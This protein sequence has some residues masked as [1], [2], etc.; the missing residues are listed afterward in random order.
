MAG[1]TLMEIKKKKVSVSVSVP[2]QRFVVKK[3]G[4]NKQVQ[5]EKSRNS[6]YKIKEENEITNEKIGKIKPNPKRE[7]GGISKRGI[8]RRK[9]ALRGCQCVYYGTTT[10][11][12][13]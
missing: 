2:K 1:S 10:E 5:K 7:K 9:I 4:E 13:P 11:N 12:L 3:R 6:E 8:V